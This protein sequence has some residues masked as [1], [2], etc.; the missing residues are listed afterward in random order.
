MYIPEDP[1]MLMSVVNAQ[2]RDRFPTLERFCKAAG[3]EESE[4]KA[5]LAA[6]NYEYDEELNQFK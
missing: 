2:L 4:L 3:L 5:K 1:V 6:I